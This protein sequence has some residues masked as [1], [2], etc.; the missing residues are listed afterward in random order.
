MEPVEDLATRCCAWKQ[1]RHLMSG[2][3]GMAPQADYAAARFRELRLL[4]ASRIDAE[5]R[6]AT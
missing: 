3:P 6:G 2:D 5:M 1:A 4:L